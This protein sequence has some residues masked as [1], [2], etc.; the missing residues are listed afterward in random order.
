MIQ[1]FLLIL[2]ILGTAIQLRAQKPHPTQARQLFG[3]NHPD[4]AVLR[5]EGKYYLTHSSFRYQPG[6]LIWESEDLQF[7]KPVAHAVTNFE[8]SIWAPELIWHEGRFYLYF[9]GVTGDRFSNWVVTAHKISGPWSEPQAVGVGHID[10]GHATANDGNRYLHLSGGHAVELTDDGLH[11]AGKPEKVH[12]GWP[13]PGDWAIECFCLESPKLT[14]LNGWFYLTTA[15][16]GTFGPST[17]HMV[18]SFRS[19]TPLGPWESSPYNPVIHTWSREE[20]WWSK[21]H[22]SLVEGPVGQWF[23]ILHGIRNG[24]RTL[25]RST[26]IEPIEWTENGWYQASGNRPAGWDKPVVIDMPLSDEFENEKL[27]I[28]WQFYEHIDPGRFGIENGILSLK[29]EGEDPGHSRPL[30]VIPRDP[31]YEIETRVTVSGKARGGLM[32][33]DSPDEFIGLSI[34]ATGQVLR[35]Q[36]N[37]R[38]YRNTEEPDL[39]THC[40]VFRIVND[41]QDVR[42]YVQQ[43]DGSWDLMQPSVEISRK[44]IVRAALFVFGKGEAGFE[45]FRYRIL[46]N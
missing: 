16:G 12:E 6:L 36:K 5:H 10:P 46:K 14:K 23:C 35:L 7:W 25:G 38:D 41:R 2:V 33:F 15:Q 13:I 4:P 22:G 34:D 3:G 20:D 44:G 28:Q 11:A 26:L 40:A 17:S 18:T 39:K 43:G 21:G 30:T 45:Y 37:Y 29:G 32:L 19:E 9:P 42:F 1:K 24:Y 27:G 8:G 31:A